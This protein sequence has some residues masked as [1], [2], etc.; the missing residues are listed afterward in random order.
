MKKILI[1]LLTV[2]MFS[3]SSFDRKELITLGNKE[4]CFWLKRK[5]YDSALIKKEKPESIFYCCPNMQ[6]DKF[7]PVCVESFYVIKGKKVW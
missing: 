2:K 7:Y 4:K 6:K 5:V 1:L 3:C